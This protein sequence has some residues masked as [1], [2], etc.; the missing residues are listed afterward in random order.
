MD[1]IGDRSDV[2][3]VGG[4][5]CGPKTGATLARRLPHAKIT[6]FQ[7]ESMLS[8]GTCGMPYYAAGEI[9]SF[10]ELTITSYGVPRSADFFKRTK[11]FDVF[12][13][14]EVTSVNRAQKTVTVRMPANGETFEHGY[15][16]LVLATGAIPNDPPFDV[17]STDR[18]RPFTRPDDAIRFRKLVEK[19]K[20]GRVV[21]VGGGFIGCELVEAAAGLWGLETVLIEKENQVLPLLLDPEMA[22]MAETEMK[23]QSV[24][25]HTSTAVQKIDEDDSGTVLVHLDDGRTIETDYVALCLGVHPEVTLARQ[26]D[27][28]LGETGCIEVDNHMRTSDSD[29]YAGGDCVES[30]YLVT[31]RKIFLPMGSLANR[32][33]RV[34]AESIAGYETTFPGVVG[35]CVLKLLDLNI[36][37][38][39]LSESAAVEA[40]VEAQVVTGVFM[41]K[42]DYYP[43][44]A[45]MVL[46]MAYAVGDMRLLG[47]QA[48]GAGDICRR[49]DVFSMFLRH[50]AAVSDLIDHEHGYAPPYAEALDPLHHL[51]AMAQ[52]QQ[53]GTNFMTPGSPDEIASRFS[54]PS[55]IVWLDVRETEEA[56]AVPWTVPGGHGKT[57]SIPLND[58]RDRLEE[59]D[60]SAEVVII[61]RRGPR[62]YQTAL[63]LAQAGFENVH[64]IGGGTTAVGMITGS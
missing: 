17:A 39:G 43:E 46:K 42:P 18:V 58:L 53:R 55:D 9:Q 3:I 27:L 31:G 25:V 7:R 62:S 1:N 57:V 16:K 48:I 52:A 33:G 41:D 49:I 2:V 40:G 60:R 4:V 63:I 35:A 37:T 13:D 5:A 44:S 36:G 21:I 23:R 14:A 6:L 34:I 54:T 15:D 12:T 10:D 45:S 56:A 61:C 38:V 11:G 51:A 29:I 19:G 59:L 8:Y 26:C 50:G 32:H 47:L 64:F 20:V 30:H 24:Q 22:R 28:K